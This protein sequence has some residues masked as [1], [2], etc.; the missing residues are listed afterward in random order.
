MVK[1]FVL[2][3]IRLF[4]VMVNFFI[5]YKI[6]DKEILEDGLFTLDSTGVR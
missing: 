4:H 5:S 6:K 1:G 2:S 3:I